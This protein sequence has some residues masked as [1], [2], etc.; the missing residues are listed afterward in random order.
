[1]VEEQF[2]RHRIAYRERLRRM[3]RLLRALPRR[4]NLGRYPVI[5]WFGAAA[6]ERPWLWTFARGPVLRAIYFGSVLSLLPLMGVQL[7]LAFVLALVA[8]CNFPLAAALQLITNPLSAVPIYG[9]TYLIGHWITHRLGGGSGEY[10][11]AAALAL[12]EH[13][14]FAGAA[15]DVLLSLTIGGI[16]AGLALGVVVDL[17]WRFLVWEARVF[18]RKLHDLHE[19]VERRR[20]ER[21]AAMEKTH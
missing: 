7:P 6:R 5:K 13:G 11:P 15:G 14:D 21:T 8:R 20:R 10:D 12:I 3:R 4:A 18:R 19:A 17:G 9:T 16:V 2:E 1:M